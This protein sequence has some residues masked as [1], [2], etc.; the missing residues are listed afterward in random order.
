MKAVLG[1][2]FIEAVARD[3]SGDLGVAAADKLCI[4]VA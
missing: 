3:A 2:E 1:Q 4:A